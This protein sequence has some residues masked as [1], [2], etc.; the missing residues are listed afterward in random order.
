MIHFF[1]RVNDGGV[2]EARRAHLRALPPPGHFT[3]RQG[4]KRPCWRW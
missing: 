4:H 1:R 2:W 3:R